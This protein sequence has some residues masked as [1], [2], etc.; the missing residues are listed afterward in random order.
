MDRPQSKQLLLIADANPE[1]LSVLKAMLAP[2]YDIIVAAD[3]MEIA[4]L[5]S[6]ADPPELILLNI[7]MTTANAYEV[8][9]T[10][11]GDRTSRDIPIILLAEPTPE[12]SEAK[13]FELGAVDYITKPFKKSIVRARIRTHLELKRCRENLENRVKM[14]DHLPPW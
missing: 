2:D 5:A 8:C 14:D 9:R 1:N 4:R 12:D 6:S 10:L 7:M 13:G 3:G 11:K